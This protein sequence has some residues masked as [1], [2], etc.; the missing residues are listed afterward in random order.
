MNDHTPPEIEDREDGLELLAFHRGKWRHVKWSEGHNGWILGYGGTF[1][2]D[3]REFAP[4]P[5][6]PANADD[7]FDWGTD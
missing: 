3:D 1:I 6:K 5:P 7:F 2:N 4:L